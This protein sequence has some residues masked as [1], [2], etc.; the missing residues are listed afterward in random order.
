MGN[1]QP[2]EKF[3]V[4]NPLRHTDGSFRHELNWIGDYQRV[5]TGGYYKGQLA[6]QTGL[7]HGMGRF[8]YIGGFLHKHEIGRYDGQF[9][10]GMRHGRGMMVCDTTSTVLAGE[11]RHNRFVGPTVI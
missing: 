3:V 7:P 8:T 1:S 10:N 4:G 2:V 5:F 9:V 6:E 11:W